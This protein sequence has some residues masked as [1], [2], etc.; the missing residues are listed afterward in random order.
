[1]ERIVAATKVAQTLAKP[2]L[3][4]HRANLCPRLF[5]R[6]LNRYPANHRDSIRRADDRERWRCPRVSALLAPDHGGA[7]SVG[8]AAFGGGVAERWPTRSQ[9]G[10]AKRTER[11]PGRPGRNRCAKSGM[12]PTPRVVPPGDPNYPRCNHRTG[13]RQAI[14]PWAFPAPTGRRRTSSSGPRAANGRRCNTRPTRRT[15]SPSSTAS[16]CPTMPSTCFPTRG[17]AC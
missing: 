9:H 4:G 12:R 15:S 6:P 7:R 16:T 17:P 10:C 2:T 3:S 1:M 5:A 14:P 13:T 11:I 8:G